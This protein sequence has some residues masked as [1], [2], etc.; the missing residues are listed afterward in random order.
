V[1]D[2]GARFA[3]EPEFRLGRPMPARW[4]T[5]RRRM[6]LHPGNSP[7][8]PP[9]KSVMT[10]CE[11]LT[12]IAFR[13][14]ITQ[15]QLA[16]LFKVSVERWACVPA[17]AV[18]EA[19]EARA[20]VA[21]DGPHCAIRWAH[22]PHDSDSSVLTAFSREGP[23]MLRSIRREHR[24]TAGTL[25]SFSTL[26]CLLREEIAAD[27]RT[28][29][30]LDEAKVQLC[31]RAAGGLLVAHGISLDPDG[32]LSA[33]ASVQVIP[34]TVFMHPAMTIT[35]WDEV[36]ADTTKPIK[37]WYNKKLPKFGD[38][39]FNTSE[40]LTVWPPVPANA[41]PLLGLPEKSTI[42][43]GGLPADLL[44]DPSALAAFDAMCQY[45]S[46][47]LAS[48]GKPP[49]RDDAAQAANRETTYPVRKGRLLY[50]YLPKDL[51]NPAR[52][53]RS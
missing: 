47:C 24:R 38:I 11:V 43:P 29:Q 32:N 7:V 22:D 33:G 36:H 14:A 25:V 13:R 45:A 23:S 35:E 4:R 17:D 49:K 16:T 53:L 19:L 8:E 28:S 1:R 26:A 41:A 9:T 5:L 34:A 40:V 12:W 18:L 6:T 2:G 27:E 50:R 42:E 21:G 51:R 48:K 20:G 15:E 39:Q 44:N 52:T 37:Y 46:K 30:Q 3:A 10:A 31:D